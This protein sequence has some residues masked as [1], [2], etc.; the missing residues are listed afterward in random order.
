MILTDDELVRESLNGVQDR[1]RE[2]FERYGKLVFRQ[3]Y[4]LTGSLQEAEDLLQEVFCQAYL[5]LNQY[6]GPGSFK[7]WI[8]TIGRNQTINLLKKKGVKT[9][10]IDFQDEKRSEF[11]DSRLDVQK[12]LETKE[13]VSSLLSSCEP[14]V[15]EVLLLRLVEDLSYREI[16][17]VVGLKEEH[18]RQIVSRGLAQLKKGAEA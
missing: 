14:V 1:F 16:S 7:K 8:L 3:S 2:L 12:V 4:A 5:K 11:A 10:S 13:S 18:L 6:R 9:F 15:R 17:E